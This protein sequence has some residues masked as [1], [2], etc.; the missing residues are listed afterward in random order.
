MKVVNLMNF[1]RKIDEKTENSTEHLLFSNRQTLLH[2]FFFVEKRII[3]C[4]NVYIKKII[5]EIEGS[6]L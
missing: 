4:Y 1:V 6:I 2:F 5:M 3:L